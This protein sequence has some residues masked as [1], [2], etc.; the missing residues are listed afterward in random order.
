MSRFIP[1]LLLFSI[2]FLSC[3]SD[4]EKEVEKSKK[5]TVRLKMERLP[6]YDSL[7]NQI[8]SRET[9]PNSHDPILDSLYQS[10]QEITDLL[11]SL[12][13]VVEKS[14][15]TGERRDIGKS[16]LT[17]SP[18]GLRLTKGANS[19]HEY[20]LEIIKDANRKESL[21]KLFAKYRG[22]L[23][24]GEFN[25]VFFSQSSTSFILMTLTGLKNDLIKATYLALLDKNELTTK[26]V[27]PHNK[28][29]AS[30]LA[31]GISIS[32]GFAVHL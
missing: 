6:S 21:K 30:T 25:L 15:P 32:F 27:R 5:I 13:I 26:T 22:Y 29:L 16:L 7:Y 24:S 9:N 20:C 18:S 4:Y 2:L 17:T 12:T 3:K 11:D 1:T 31:E 8:I 19:I 10:T 23:G 28:G 14:D